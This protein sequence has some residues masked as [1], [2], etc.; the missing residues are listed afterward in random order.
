MICMLLLT[1]LCV[2]GMPASAGIASA[3]LMPGTDLH[4]IRLLFNS[5][6]SSPPLPKT[7]G[8]PPFNL[9]TFFPCDARLMR[10]CS[11]SFCPAEGLWLRLPTYI[12]SALSGASSSRRLSIKSYTTASQPCSSLKP[13]SVIHSLLP[14]PA[15]TRLT[16]PAP[17]SL[18]PSLLSMLSA[19]S[20][21]RYLLRASGLAICLFAA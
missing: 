19:K 6:I 12:F 5:C 13:S 20:C 2:T 16:Q 9:T 21:F 8:S 14:Q 17:F 11:I 10:I 15:P 4:G 3:E 1:P 7:K 18:K